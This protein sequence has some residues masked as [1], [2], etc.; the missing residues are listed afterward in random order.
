[1]PK[2]LAVRVGGRLPGRID[3]PA[4]AGTHGRPGYRHSRYGGWLGG[5]LSRF[6][7][8]VSAS[9][10]APDLRQTTTYLPIR[11]CGGCVLVISPSVPISR[12][13]PG[14]SGVTA[15]TFNF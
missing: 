6:Q 8:S 15:T 12:A 9:H 5:Y 14:P 1:M 10:C 7:I 13:V 4:K 11:G 3:F 2:P